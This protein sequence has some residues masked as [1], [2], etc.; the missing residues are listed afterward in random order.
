MKAERLTDQRQD[1]VDETI[2]KLVIIRAGGTHAAN[3]Y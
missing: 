2:E 3:S 1:T